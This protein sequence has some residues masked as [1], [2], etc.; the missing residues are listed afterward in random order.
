MIIKINFTRVYL[1]SREAGESAEPD[2][3]GHV[4]II[5]SKTN[6]S[7]YSYATLDDTIHRFNTVDQLQPLDGKLI[8]IERIGLNSNNDIEELVLFFSEK[9]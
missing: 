5:P 6:P 9:K 4:S 1:R 8:S 3:I 7:P 2:Q